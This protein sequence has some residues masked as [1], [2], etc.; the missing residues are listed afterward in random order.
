MLELGKE[1]WNRV[2]RRVTAGWYMGI[3]CGV[4]Y[5]G[6]IWGGIWGS[7]MGWDMG[8]DMGVGYARIGVGRR[9]LDPMPGAG[10]GPSVPAPRWAQRSGVGR[11]AR[12]RATCFG[13]RRARGLGRRARALGREACTQAVRRDM[14]RAGLGAGCAGLRVSAG[15]G[16]RR[17]RPSRSAANKPFH[18]RVLTRL[19]LGPP[20]G[21]DTA[22]ARDTHTHTHTHVRGV[23]GGWP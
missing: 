17:P 18:A 11:R 16:P 12:R 4:G 2:H 23:P 9:V 5:G 19:G 7:D 20:A 6:R 22:V 14:T 10:S 3:G 21:L 1:A 13:G 8:W 15:F